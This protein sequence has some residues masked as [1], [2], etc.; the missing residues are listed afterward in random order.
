MN[1]DISF[2]G[3]SFAQKPSAPRKLRP[4]LLGFGIFLGLCGCWLLLPE[5]LRHKTGGLRYD[6]NSAVAASAHQ[7]EAL[8]AAQ[9]GLIRGDLWAEAAFADSSLLWLD[10]SASPNR[11]AAARLE[12][13]RSHA[14]TALAFAPINGAAWLFLAA[15]PAS[16][17]GGGDDSIATLLEMSYFTA[18]N[19]LDLARLRIERAATS[20][21]IADKDIQEFIKSDIRKILAYRPEQ[22]SAII[23]AYRTAWPQNQ[24][25][26][27][28]LATDV[29][30]TFGQSLR[31]GPSK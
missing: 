18:P 4:A 27:E 12:R 28:T 17:S 6:R 31:A 2:S 16:A 19:D 7:V 11:A 8:E 14:E 13:A 26:L 22:K 23:A 9:I 25:M 3:S 29:D 10:R 30:P 24:P 21:A 1:S 20:N 5:L 15:L